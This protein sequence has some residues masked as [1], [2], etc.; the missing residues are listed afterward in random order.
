MSFVFDEQTMAQMMKA[1]DASRRGRAALLATNTDEELSVHAGRYGISF[2]THGNRLAMIQAVISV[3]YP[4]LTEQTS[5]PNPGEESPWFQASQAPAASASE[6]HNVYLEPQGMPNEY[7]HMAPRVQPEVP[8]YP[9]KMIDDF[10]AAM[11]QTLRAG[12]GPA[13]ASEM[14]E[15]FFSGNEGPLEGPSPVMARATVKNALIT[16]LGP[17]LGVEGVEVIIN[18]L[19]TDYGDFTPKELHEESEAVRAQLGSIRTGDQVARGLENYMRGSF[20]TATIGGA[21]EAAMG[22]FGGNVREWQNPD[23]EKTQ[24]NPIVE[25]REVDPSGEASYYDLPAHGPAGGN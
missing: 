2:D 12:S 24:I 9:A 15:D 16:L 23:N 1:R 7:A 17:A 18:Y 21:I 10:L 11:Y 13:S 5:M 3:E 19:N 20:S 8:T 22:R 25:S 6:T 14:I 4:D